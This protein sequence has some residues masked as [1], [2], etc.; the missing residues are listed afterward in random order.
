MP[1]LRQADRETFA[2]DQVKLIDQLAPWLL[3]LILGAACVRG[4]LDIA[5]VEPMT[6]AVAQ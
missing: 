1:V 3:A 4:C 5:D 6:A 2:G